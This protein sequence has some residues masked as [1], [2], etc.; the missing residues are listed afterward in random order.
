MLSHVLFCW[1]LLY[2]LQAS[3]WPPVAA[4]PAGQNCLVFLLESCLITPNEAT[5]NKILMKLCLLLFFISPHKEIVI[6]FRSRFLNPNYSEILFGLC[7]KWLCPQCCLKDPTTGVLLPWL[8]TCATHGHWMW[9][10]GM[11]PSLYQT[12]QI[13]LTLSVLTTYQS[14]K[15]L[16]LFFLGNVIDFVVTIKMCTLWFSL[17]PYSRLIKL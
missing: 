16:G 5:F 13:H 1:Y 7:Q 8:T 9:Q 4:A 11:W 15:V 12:W 2:A 17:Y 14:R 10:C 6:Y 3:F